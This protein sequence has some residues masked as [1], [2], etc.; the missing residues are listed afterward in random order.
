MLM[1]RKT[2]RTI[3]ALVQLPFIYPSIYCG[4]IQAARNAG[5]FYSGKR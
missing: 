2:W 1:L 5:N 4:I 3:V